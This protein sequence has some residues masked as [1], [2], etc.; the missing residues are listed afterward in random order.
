MEEL[1]IKLHGLQAYENG[2]RGV[3]C[4]RTICTYLQLGDTSSAIAVARN[5]SDKIRNY[6]KI[7]AILCQNLVELH[8]IS[9]FPCPHRNSQVS[10]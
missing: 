10:E 5:E 3:H 1:A 8:P 7:E 9:L 6:P 2:G 4:V